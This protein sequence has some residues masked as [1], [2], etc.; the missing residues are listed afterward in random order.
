MLHFAET[1]DFPEMGV[2]SDS[3]FCDFTLSPQIISAQAAA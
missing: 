1:V 2:Q 3:L